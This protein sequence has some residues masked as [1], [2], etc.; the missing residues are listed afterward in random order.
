MP[1]SAPR[2]VSILAC[3]TRHTPTQL[4]YIRGGGVVGVEMRWAWPM[5]MRR[6]GSWGGGTFWSLRRNHGITP[7][8]IHV[9]MRKAAEGGGANVILCT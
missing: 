9:T 2:S 7:E 6:Q 1:G 5:R 8:G 4:F 3:E